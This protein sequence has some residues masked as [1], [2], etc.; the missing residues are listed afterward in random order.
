MPKMQSTYREVRRMQ[1][2]EVYVHHQ[3]LPTYTRFSILMH[4]LYYR[5]S[6][7]K[8]VLLCLR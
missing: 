5:P 2:D 4:W 8:P 3:E 6:M 1:L 7:Q